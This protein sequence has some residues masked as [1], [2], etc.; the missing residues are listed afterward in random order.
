[1]SLKRV[2]RRNWLLVAL[3]YSVFTLATAYADHPTP[4]NTT[5][6]QP[7]VST[8]ETN[9]QFEI[10][11]NREDMKQAVQEARKTVK[12][13]IAQLQKPGSSDTHFEIKKRFT[14][15]NVSEHVWL[16]DVKFVENRF[17]GR[18]DDDP[19]DLPN[20]K[21]GDLVSVNPS[22]ISDWA[23]VS[24]GKLV[25]G[26]TIRVRYKQM[27]PAEKAQFEKEVDFRIE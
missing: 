18:I 9:N 24:N 3:S 25:G 14:Y 26:Y 23:Y 13:F 22:E 11:K 21:I 17:Q 6:P 10:Q 5:A 20:I 19:K 12:Q 16:S 7:N 8:D 15:K 2:I 27:S 1:M 4:M